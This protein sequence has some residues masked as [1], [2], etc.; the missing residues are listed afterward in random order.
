VSPSAL[1]RVLPPVGDPIRLKNSA[2]SPAS[3]FDSAGR[4]VYVQSG[5]AALALI[6][7]SL[8]E[9]AKEAGHARREVLLPAYGCPDI[10]SAVAFAGCRARLVDL[11]GDSPFPSARAWSAAIGTDTLALVTVGF[12]GMRD[13]YTPVAATESGL[14]PGAFVEDCCQVHPMAAPAPL[15]RNVALSFGRGKPVSMMHGGLAALAPGVDRWWSGWTAPAGGFTPFAKV[16]VS[17]GLYNVLRS[18]WLYPWVT[19]LPG[20]GVGQTEYVPLD[21]IARMNPRIRDHLDLH[22]GWQDPRRAALQ[23]ALRQGLAAAHPAGLAADLWRSF[24][25]EGD[26]LLRYPLLLKSRQARDAALAALNAAGLGA[27]PM[28]SRALVDIPGVEPALAGPAS[29]PGARSFA[30]RFLTLPLHADVRDADAESM[31][32]ILSKTSHA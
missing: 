3:V 13:P 16:R 20:L 25:D 29:T 1:L 14:Q 21:G 32:H 30:D 2:Q 8:V 27:S 11:E 4:A 19:R 23:R 9:R 10:I 24:G 28:Y 22:R 17:V 7:R 6:L 5:T 26:W 31:F 15:D 12:L 18:P